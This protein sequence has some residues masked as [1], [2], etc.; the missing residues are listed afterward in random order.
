M[1]TGPNR[2][3]APG[4]APIHVFLILFSGAVYPL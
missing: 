3:V 2:P 1:S 4:A